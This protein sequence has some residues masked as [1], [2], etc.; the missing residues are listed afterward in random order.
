MQCLR[1]GN[2]YALEETTPNTELHAR[3]TEASNPD[4]R[5]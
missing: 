2:E 3:E 5:A 4:T 1:F